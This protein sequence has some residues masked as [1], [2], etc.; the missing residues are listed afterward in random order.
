MKVTKAMKQ[1]YIDAYD[2]IMEAAEDSAVN[3]D[4][5]SAMGNRLCGIYDVM[6]AVTLPTGDDIPQDIED[7]QNKYEDALMK[8]LEG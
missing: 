1:C 6:Q 4:D 7:M 8:K 3:F 5:F 2:F